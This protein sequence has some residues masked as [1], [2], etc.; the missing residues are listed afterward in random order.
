[1][2]RCWGA[3]QTRMGGVSAPSGAE[4]ILRVS[5]TLEHAESKD[6]V[7]DGDGE[8]PDW[9]V[10]GRWRKSEDG[11]RRLASS[12]LRRRDRQTMLRHVVCHW[13]AKKLP[14]VEC[15]YRGTSNQLQK[16]TPSPTVTLQ[17]LCSGMRKSAR[18][19]R[20]VDLGSRVSNVQ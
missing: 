2:T 11:G 16:G 7:D 17:V 13:P 5:P 4:G 9:I 20:L 18:R 15:H 12:Q 1:M 3:R 14:R 19:S 6:M 8:Q 10:C